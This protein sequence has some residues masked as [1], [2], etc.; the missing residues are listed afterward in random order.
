M[1]RGLPRTAGFALANGRERL[2]VP[3]SL[4]V[5]RRVVPQNH[6]LDSV[7][8]LRDDVADWSA[9]PFCVP[10]LQRFERMDLHPKVTFLVGENGS[11]KSTFL[12]A[13]AEKLG[14]RSSGGSRVGNMAAR[15]YESPLAPRLRIA[16]T[17]NRPSDGFFLRAESFHNWATELDELEATPFCGGVLA[18]YCGKRLHAQSHGESFLSLLTQRLRGH[19]VYLFDEPEA[20][21]SPQ[22]QLAML[23]RMHD[24]TEEFS[25]FIIATHSPLL[26]A[27]PGAW[28]Y[29]FG[30]DGVGRVEFEETEHYRVTRSV[31]M[32]HKAM[33]KKLLSDYS[34][35]QKTD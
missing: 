10:A 17:R 3:R 16:R 9:F 12:E 15:A 27:F 20:A 31:M 13:L 29:Q 28:I 23:V 21:L 8:L 25:Q 22:R 35:R 26:M 2:P 30:P 14:F 18:S 19:G 33:M 7:S 34:E 5:L 1:R 24:L 4:F 11:G 6:Y 32:D